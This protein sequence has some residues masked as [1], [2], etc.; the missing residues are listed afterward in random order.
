MSATRPDCIRFFSKM[1]PAKSRGATAL[2]WAG[3]Y[4]IVDFTAEPRTRSEEPKVG[5]CR[6]L[7]IS[8]DTQEQRDN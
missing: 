5:H 3:T 8:T 1:A 6:S 4:L 7:L 2:L